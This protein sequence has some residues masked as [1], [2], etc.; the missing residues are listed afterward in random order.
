L[1]SVTVD[2][3]RLR[4]GL[5]SKEIA[6]AEVQTFIDEAAGYLSGQTGLKLDPKNCAE[7]QAKAIADLAA[8][9]CWLK[10]T[11]ISAVGWTATLGEITFSG[12][13]ER[14]VQLEVFRRQVQ[15]WIERNR[16]IYVG[17]A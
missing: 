11:G 4:L 9:Y 6:D 16:K 12:P 15:A 13:A 1:A 5:T 10:V 8:I 7:D 14:V 17:R 2:R 3:V